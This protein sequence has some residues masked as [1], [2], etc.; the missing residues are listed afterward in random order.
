MQKADLVGQFFND[1]S[2]PRYGDEIASAFKNE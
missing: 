1:H 2:N